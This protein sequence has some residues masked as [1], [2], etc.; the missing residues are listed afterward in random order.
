MSTDE[1]I[2]LAAGRRMGRLLRDRRRD[3]LRFE[4]DPAW[5]DDERAFPLSLSMPMAVQ[6]HADGVVEPFLWGLLPDNEA[7]LR[8]WGELFSVSPRHAFKLITHVGEDC[9]GA[10]QFV[11]PER[12]AS[13][14][15]V[16]R[17][18]QVDWLD[19]E[20]VAQRLQLLVSDHAAS[21]L[22]TDRGRFSL[23][24]A[25]PKTALLFDPKQSRWGVPFGRTPTTHILKPATGAFDGFA[26][27]EHFCISLA[28][29]LGLPAAKSAILNFGSTSVFVTERYDRVRRG[30]QIL[31]V[32]QEDMCQALGRMPHAKYQSDGGPTPAEIARLLQS[33]GSAAHEDTRRFGD[34]LL[35]SWLLV[36]TDAHAKNYSL[37]LGDH[38]S[39]RL[40]PLYDLASAL[41]YPRQMSLRT[42][43]LAMKIGGE[44]RVRA[45]ANSHWRRAATELGVT[46]NELRERLAKLAADLP[47]AAAQVHS[48]MENGAVD[49]PV[50]ARL[51]T[52]IGERAALAA[53]L[54]AK[55]WD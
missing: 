31:R 24:G 39:V 43:K 21:R 5:C 14:S 41:P 19:D 38:G 28:R 40:A 33:H 13:L 51:V 20:Q 29:T 1:L 12:E 32:H 37:L 27:N 15:T 35:L 3:A 26:E 48:E 45:V 42:A 44:Y 49:H 55:P 50:V 17:P 18:L 53:Q 2:A 6:S 22:G 34:A 54:A 4:Y 9:A 23:A 36:G 47:S 8:R 52:A 30:A 11:S 16:R 10:V 46:P 7:V 25:Q